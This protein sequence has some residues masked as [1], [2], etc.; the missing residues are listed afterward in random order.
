MCFYCTR[1][2]FCT[3]ISHFSEVSSCLHFMSILG[4]QW[5]PFV[6]P[7][8]AP[9]WDGWAAATGRG[10]HWAPF[11]F[12]FLGCLGWVGRSNG[13]GPTGPFMFP[14]W[15]GLGC[16]WAPFVCVFGLLVWMGGPRRRGW[17][18]MGSLRLFLGWMGGPRRQGWAPDGL[19]SCFPFRLVNWPRPPFMS[20]FWAP[21]LLALLGSG[22]G[23]GAQD[24]AGLGYHWAPMRS[25]GFLSSCLA[26]LGSACHQNQKCTFADMCTRIF[27]SCSRC[28]TPPS[29]TQDIAHCSRNMH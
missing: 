15:A 4:S 5:A 23:A 3:F 20:P 21:V 2:R 12:S 17:V 14:F 11:M 19:P 26:S 7:F 9:G 6:F 8:W 24:G 1:H 18:P 22:D 28:Q 27:V 10:C 13:S 29:K 16:R 25:H